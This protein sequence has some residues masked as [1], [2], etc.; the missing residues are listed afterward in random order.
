MINE[1]TIRCWW[2]VLKGEGKLTEVRL[3]AKKGGRQKNYSGYF[4]SIDSLLS[5]LA[6]FAD[7]DYGIYYTLNAINEACYGRIQ[8]ERFV[9]NPT[10]TS[11]QDVMG[12]DLVLID[13]DPKRPSD[14]NASDEEVKYAWEVAQRIRDFLRDSGFCF[15]VMAMSGNGVH[16]LYLVQMANTPAVQELVKDFLK[17]LD[18]M[19]GDDRID[20]DT[21]VFNASRIAKMI[22]T[23]S[24]KGFDSE[25]RPQRLS[26][27]IDIPDTFEVT[28]IAYFQKI[29]SIIPK[30]EKPSRYNR[31]APSEDFDVEAFFAQHNIAI[32]SVSKFS[33]GTKYVLEECPFNSNHK[34]PDAAVFK[35][36][37]GALGFRCLHASCQQYSWRDFR[38]HYDPQAY[39]RR[40]YDEHLQLQ[41]YYA[42]QP[43][44]PPQPLP[45][46]EEKGKKWLD[47]TDI[48]YVNPAKLPFVPTGILELDKKV[49]GL[50]MG[51]V[52]IIS[53]LSGA[54]KT[55]LLDNIILNVIQRNYKVACWS[56]ELQDFRFQSWLDQM[57][58]GK[59]YVRQATGYE[60]LYFAPQDVCKQVNEWLKGKLFLYNNDYGNKW[61]QLFA[62]IQEIVES[63]GVSVV[64]IDNLMALNLTY[65]GEKN[66]KQTQF[67]NELKDY[68]KRKNIH[69]ILVCHPRKEQSYQLLRMESISGTAD[70]TNLCDN[71]FI[72]H[73]VGR[74]FERRAKEFFGDWV[75][76]NYKKYDV[77]LEV[78][79]NRS[80]GIKDFL[81]GMYYEKESRRLKND[82]A[83][84]IV[85]GWQESGEDM[86]LDI[87]ESEFDTGKDLP[88]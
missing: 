10:T 83:E 21:S 34:H 56:G 58:A 36:D 24:N 84:H 68:T 77:V 37:N 9:E 15:P 61:N 59:N 79:K 13:L 23:R 4:K 19:F 16:L 69:V 64:V 88:F 75:I 46:T 5:A 14:T 74:D 45:E 29:A 62:D 7:S 26:Y 80:Y 11:D 55:S 54:G 85:Y 1:S 38:L 53:G 32:H 42:P 20:V 52:T 70:L 71:L 66:E 30:Q 63:Q 81:V 17:A 65:M 82:I 6:P 57:A 35:L 41:Q 28:D 12:R 47:M 18:M 39:D 8:R 22:G 60:D 25:E 48:K 78:C 72:I 76:D 73:R 43:P 2:A 3:L 27:F 44:A 33:G 67:I 51:D 87:Y 86:P 40:A 31:F 50:M 49:M